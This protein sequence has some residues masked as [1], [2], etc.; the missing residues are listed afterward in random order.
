MAG[1]NEDL[2]PDVEL[3][4]PDLGEVGN[5]ARATVTDG[6]AE[7]AGVELPKEPA[8]KEP[9]DGEVVKE[10]VEK[11]APTAKPVAAAP[12]AEVAPTEKVPD[13]WRPEAKAEWAKVPPT[14]RAEIVKRE[15]DIAKFVGDTKTDVLISTEVKKVFAPYAKDYQRFGIEPISH[16]EGLLRGYHSILFGSPE[17][18]VQVLQALAKDAGLDI[19]KLAAG[20]PAG[21]AVNADFNNALKLRDERIAQLEA[22]FTGVSTQIQ[23]QRETELSADVL[24]F[25]QTH[26]AFFELAD[27]ITALINTGAVKS[28]AEAYEIAELRNPTTRAKRLDAE[29]AAI[30]TTQAAKDAEKAT[31][32]RAASGANVRSRGNQR[33]A[34]PEETIDD[35]IRQGLADIRARTH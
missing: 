31:K 13:T 9:I 14:V 16:M 27:D 20:I 11:P 4:L 24:A 12:V 21:Q 10:G 35:T 6:I 32:A 22:G 7:A 8:E 28:L 29:R 5:E 19:A 2:H 18:K 17:D 30:A 25:A 1:E 15:G 3:G 26:P 23:K 33:A 34:A